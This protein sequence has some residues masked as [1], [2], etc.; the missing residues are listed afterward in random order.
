MAVPAVSFISAGNGKVR[1]SDA[2]GTWVVNAGSMALSTVTYVEGTGSVG[3]KVSAATRTAY[4]ITAADLTG[5]PWNFSSGGAD[6]GEHIVVWLYMYEGWDTLANGGFGIIV[7]DDLATDSF[8]TW[9]VGPQSGYIGGWYPYIVSPKKNF[10]VVTAGTAGWTTT[11]N[12]A[13]LTGVDGFG[14]RWSVLST[15]SGAT[16]NVYLDAIIV[17][18]GYQVVSG[19][20]ADPDCTFANFVTFEEAT[21]T[22]RF[23]FLRPVSGIPFV[24]G[25]LYI[26]DTGSLSTVFTDSGFTV[27]WEKVT[28]SDGTSSAVDDLFYELK[29]QKGSGSTN[30]TMSQGV[31]KALSPH[32]VVLNFNGI[33]AASLD[34]VN[35]DR[36]ATITLDSAVTW[37]D[38][39]L[40]NCGQ[41]IASGSIFTGNVVSGS[42]VAA[43]VAALVWND[44]G[45]PDG[46]LD[47]CTFVKGTNAHHAIQ[48]GASAPASVTLRGITFTG[49]DAANEAN[50][51][52]I[53]LADT[54]SN[55]AWTINAVGCSGTVS[56]KKTRSGDT[57]T[58]VTD[59]VTTSIHVQD[60][61]TAAAITSARVL[62][63]CA[64]GGGKPGDVTVTITAVT[65]TAT[66]SHTA[67]GLSTGDKVLIKGA[68]LAAYNGVKT[69]TVTGANA[70]T[71]TMGS[72]PASPAV[73]T[74]K[75]SL[76]VI[77]AAVDG[78][79]DASDTRSWP[80]DQ[81]ITGR[82]RKGSASTYY[83]SSPITGTID[84]VSGFSATIQMIPDA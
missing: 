30:V 3:D 75:A 80:S 29:F 66:V 31:L 78:S 56:V 72:S 53:L 46:N 84:S 45:D 57:Y 16:D 81:P 28:L 76:V 8:G 64:A 68:T 27:V 11:G 32:T 25:K 69:I 63:Y 40:T 50:G 60:V 79:G 26:G 35:V 20:G 6:D 42:T 58:V 13:Q 38:S 48:L 36:G 37:V 22:G 21:T 54:G 41:I 52:V 47:D 59:P 15:I 49:F 9:Y 34:G 39:V 73:G 24:R 4:T 74:I 44:A 83:K 65:T 23:G 2:V 1:T 70:Y 12:P 77:D 62:V 55:R 10:N 43:D 67:H 82:V 14:A 19:D 51:S 33:T 17:G 71:Y 7:A 18:K 5:E 61:N